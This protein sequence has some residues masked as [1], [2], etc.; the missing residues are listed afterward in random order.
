MKRIL[1]ML[2]ALVMVL[3]LAAMAPSA[4]AYTGGKLV[5]LTFDDGPG[6]YTQRLLDGLKARD[7]KATFFMVGQNV[8]R[9]PE[10]VERMYQEGHQLANHSYDHANFTDCSDSEI[11]SQLD[12]TNRLLDMAA[13]KGSTYMV[14][15]PYGSTNSRV[16]A[17]VGA[18]LTYWSVDP[19]DW[20][21]RDAA[22][23]KNRIVNNAHD[24]AIILV[25]DIHATSVD[26]ALAAIDVLQKEGYEFV[27][28]REL[29]RR[30]G[31]TLENGVQYYSCK[32]TG[33]DLG[34]VAAPS[35]SAETKNGQM[36]ITMTAQ[37][38]AEIYYSTSGASLNQE[39]KRYTGPFTVSGPCTVW[40]VAAYN[41]NGSRSAVA[42]QSFTKPTA[43]APKINISEE[44]VLTLENRTEGASLFYTLDGTA[45]TASSTR[46]TGPITL[47][48]GTV[49]SACAGGD[50]YLTSEAVRAT[51]SHLGHF[52]RD[53]FPYHWYYEA[54]DE[55]AEAGYLLGVGDGVYAP[56]RFVTRAQLVTLLYRFSG[57][58]VTQEQRDNCPFTDLAAGQ[59]YVDAVSWAYARGIVNGYDRETFLPDRQVKRQEMA[60]IF[61]CYL[62]SVNKALPEGVDVSGMFS[63]AGKISGWA[64]DYV[65]QVVATGLMLGN[66]EGTFRPEASATRAQAATMLIRLPEVMESLPEKPAE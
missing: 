53:V 5:A 24:G 39:S 51:Y 45:A 26:G 57:E 49:V 28:V 44:G 34:P 19:Q 4:R 20:K 31:V 12:K 52:F 14:R 8:A 15:A 50:D 41:M 38:G 27:T 59:Y 16:R 9:Y 63:D 1:S 55:A 65:G 6:P 37:A 43:Q 2:L 21:D 54:M 3:G 58:T 11:R 23:V 18:P 33:K 66:K 35:I 47:E 10:T 30:R 32:P 48:P 36:V 61:V 64:K 29:F 22:I 40:A 60:K 13:G 7:A 46:Y 56:E 62:E 42:S 25:H 17:A